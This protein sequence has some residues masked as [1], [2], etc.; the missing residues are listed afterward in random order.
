MQ[1]AGVKI[2]EPISEKPDFKMKSFIVEGPNQ[3]AIEVVEG[4]PIPEGVWD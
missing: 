3:V 1:A 2:L 4:K